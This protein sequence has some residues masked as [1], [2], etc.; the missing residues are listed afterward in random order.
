VEVPNLN[1]PTIEQHFAQVARNVQVQDFR[2]EVLAM[3]KD[4]L[5]GQLIM[6][7]AAHLELSAAYHSMAQTCL[8]Q[9]QELERQ[10]AEK[11]GFKDYEKYKRGGF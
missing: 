11:I 5:R 6:L 10:L 3:S 9:H 4:E 7:Y 8:K 1:E 2:S